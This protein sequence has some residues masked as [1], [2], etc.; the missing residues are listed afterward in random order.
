MCVYIFLYIYIQTNPQVNTD[1]L[2][3]YFKESKYY[4]SVSIKPS[5]KMQFQGYLYYANE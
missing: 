1:G 3:T 4:F 2:G 5:T